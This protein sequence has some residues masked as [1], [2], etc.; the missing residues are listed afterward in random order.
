[1]RKKLIALAA[2]C[3]FSASAFAALSVDTSSGVLEVSSSLGG[4]Q[5]VIA[6][7]MSP[8]DQLIVDQTYAG[9][10]F[11]W[12]PPA[13]ANGAYRYDVRV[14]T[15]PDD[16]EGAG[17]EGDAAQNNESASTEE[18]AGGSVEVANGQIEQP[19]AE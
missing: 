9:N 15:T 8:D 12:T 18:Y 1:M 7:V 6:K 4:N 13:G 5:K 11:T 2:T 16:L 3:L 19:T 10:S 14:I 17:A